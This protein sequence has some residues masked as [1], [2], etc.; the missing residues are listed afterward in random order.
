MSDTDKLRDLMVRLHDEFGDI[1]DDARP[2]LNQMAVVGK[3]LHARH[4][5][6]RGGR[7]RRHDH[8]RLRIHRAHVPARPRPVQASRRAATRRGGRRMSVCKQK[9]R[10][11][12]RA[13]AVWALHRVPFDGMYS[14]VRV[15]RC[16]CGGWHLTSRT[17]KRWGH[18]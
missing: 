14:P 18:R 12:S 8:H 7:R 15:Y 6:G 5:P 17:G 9:V 16:H 3:L 11:P 4:G 10:Y 2:A 1:W 13:A